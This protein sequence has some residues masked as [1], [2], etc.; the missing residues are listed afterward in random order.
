MLQ[1]QLV[2]FLK[3]TVVISRNGRC[4][5]VLW[6]T[7]D[8]IV[9]R[10]TV[11]NRRRDTGVKMGFHRFPSHFFVVS[12]VDERS[13]ALTFLELWKRQMYT[14]VSSLLTLIWVRT[15][16]LN[17]PL[18]RMFSLRTLLLFRHRDEEEKKRKTPCRKRK[19]EKSAQ[20]KPM[21]YNGTV[22]QFVCHSSI[23][24]MRIKLCHRR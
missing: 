22:R 4:L 2:L 6:N 5:L 24:F 20:P 17:T 11:R 16:Y 10:F 14:T 1:T 9:H 12:C 3:E 15:I 19:N 7:T 18:L 21:L 23:I 8:L 13:S